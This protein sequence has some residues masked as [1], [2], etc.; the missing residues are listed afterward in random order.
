MVTLLTQPV[1]PWSV[2]RQSPVSAS[3]TFSVLSH[4]PDTIVRPS[5][6]MTTLATGSIC[7]WSVCRQAPDWASQTLTVLSHEPETI[8]RPSA[9]RA[10]LLTGP[11]CPWSVIRQAGGS[12]WPGRLFHSR[13]ARGSVAVES[14]G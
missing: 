5:A 14:G 7:P 1:C 9:E 12:Q 8:V 4:E 6:E 11:V 3:Q 2:W 10:T 13:N